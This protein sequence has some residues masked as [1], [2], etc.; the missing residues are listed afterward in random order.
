MMIVRN[1]SKFVPVTV[2]IAQNNGQRHV[3][4]ELLLK[5]GV[6][7]NEGYIC[8][9][10]LQLLKLDIS[11]LSRITWVKT[12]RLSRNGIESLPPDISCYLK[13]V[14]LNAVHIFGLGF[15]AVTLHTSRFDQFLVLNYTI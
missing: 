3:R 14:R 4:E 15:L 10:G 6:S 2:E 5:T 7:Q 1:I 9:H 8:W 12:L 13:Q 11:L